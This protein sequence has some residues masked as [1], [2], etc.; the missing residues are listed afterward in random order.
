MKKKRNYTEIL[1]GIALMI[2]VGIMPLVVRLA[3]RPLPPELLNYFPLD[4]DRFRGGVYADM[5]T[6]W[7]GMVV[8]AA[9]IVIAFFAV[10]DWITNG[11][12]PNYREF[13]KMPHVILSGVFILLLIISALASPFRYT[14][15]WGTFDRGEGALMWLAYFV[16]FF[17][18]V[19]YAQKL[20][21]VKFILYALAFS[22]IIMGVIG[23][24]QLFGR[25]FFGTDFARLLI[26]LGD[27]NMAELVYIE[28]ELV[29]RRHAINPVFDIANGTLFNPNTFGKYTAMLSPVLLLAALTYEGKRFVRWILLFAGGLMLV[30]VFASGSLGG[31]VGIGTASVVLIVTYLFRPGIPLKKIGLTALPV[32]V[33]MAGAILFI[34][35]LNYRV[36]FMATRVV[37]ALRADTTDILNYSFDENVMRVFNADGDV[38]SL[39]VHGMTGDWITVRDAQGN[40]LEPYLR[41]VPPPPPR[42]EPTQAPGAIAYA[43]D[44]PGYRMIRLDKWPG[45]F[46]YH[47]ASPVTPF[48][49]TH[50]HG[51]IYVL[52]LNGMPID[53][54]EN[55]PSWGFY[56]RET[57]GSSRGYI[58]SRSFPLMFTPRALTIGHGPDT[59]INT[60]PMFDPAPRMRFFNSP[61][62]IVDKAHNVF[63]QTWISSGAWSAIALFALFGHYIFTTFFSLVKSKEEPLFS[64]G[65]RLGLLSGISASV[66]A[67]MATDTTIGSTGVFFVL[68]GVGYGVNLYF[69]RQAQA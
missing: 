4:S 30:G 40:E 5:F 3:I 9:A 59:F 58:W 51:R 28:G 57:F 52:N 6:Y 64:Y 14:A 25:D 46:F 24:S 21:N 13:F 62:I 2:V 39:E 35:Q 22:S 1:I 32:V 38:F 69:K 19:D 48:I 31:F 10:S 23:L 44:I 26:T 42:D 15:F 17:A 11:K 20:E 8:Y 27:R 34:P 53:V 56:G 47:H 37:N 65:L 33:V 16:I 43:F 60:F 68:L 67:N 49:L 29:P 7:K 66:M 41:N 63:I 55:A 12:L 61:Y 54:Q 50:S 18:A 36:G 45:M